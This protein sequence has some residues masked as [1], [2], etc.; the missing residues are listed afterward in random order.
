MFEMIVLNR[1]VL[2]V[3]IV[4]CSDFY[5]DAVMYTPSEYRKAAYWQWTMWRVRYLGRGVRKVIPSCVVWCICNKYP[6]LNGNY[7]GLKEY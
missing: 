5:G 3:A 1:D 2:S 6:S 7:L 4:H